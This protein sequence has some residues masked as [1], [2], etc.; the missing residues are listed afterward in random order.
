MLLLW[1]F[2][3]IVSTHAET[4]FI[5]FN[6][7]SVSTG[8]ISVL[9]RFDTSYTI[10][11]D[12]V[13]QAGSDD[14]HVFMFSS[15]HSYWTH[16]TPPYVF[17]PDH[18]TF[19]RDHVCCLWDIANTYRN[20]A[21]INA[22]NSTCKT[23]SWLFQPPRDVGAI[24]KN[25]EPLN[26]IR[27]AEST[28]RWHTTLQQRPNFIV[29]VF[30]YSNPFEIKYM[31]T[32]FSWIQSV[33]GLQAQWKGPQCVDVQYRGNTVCIRCDNRKPDHSVFVF[34]SRWM[35]T[36]VCDWTCA[37]GYV[38]YKGGCIAEWQILLLS[39]VCFAAVGIASVSIIMYQR[40][41][42][43]RQHHATNPAKAQWSTPNNAALKISTAKSL[44]MRHPDIRKLNISKLT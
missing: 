22:L 20:Y 1:V 18:E 13:F 16:K 33:A 37:N 19:C 23:K 38:E 25:I 26:I 42:H 31:A 15:F 41:T 4:S 29:L 24:L 7:P 17:L 40:T 12:G 8:D 35:N 14:F 36:Y 44:T 43:I 34:T 21:W 32:E 27:S 5:E 3:F 6:T 2:L 28:Y 9:E 10:S 39:A 30:I 11:L